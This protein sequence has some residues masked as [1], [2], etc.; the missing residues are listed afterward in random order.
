LSQKDNYFKILAIGLLFSLFF[1][2]CMK[3]SDLI[4]NESESLSKTA[5]D[6]DIVSDISEYI[7]TFCAREINEEYHILFRYPQFN[8]MFSNV[9]NINNLILD[10]VKIAVGEDF[11][12]DLRDTSE[13]CEWDDTDYSLKAIN[14]NYE[15]TRF[16]SDYLSII[17]TGE[18]HH[19]PAAYPNDYFSTLVVDLNKHK[20]IAL[21]DLYTVNLSFTELLEEEIEKQILLSPRFIN[22]DKNQKETVREYLKS[23]YSSDDLLKKLRSNNAYIEYKLNFYLTYEKLGIVF[24]LIHSI[25]D[26]AVALINYDELVDFI[27]DYNEDMRE[28]ISHSTYEIDSTE[29]VNLNEEKEINIRIIFPQVI[30]MNDLHIQN[31]IN[32][33]I[34]EAALKP[35]KFYQ[36]YIFADGTEWSFDGTEWLIEYSIVF[37]TDT[38]LSIKFKGYAYSQGNASGVNWVYAVNIDIANGNVITSDE[39]F[40][41]SFKNNIRYNIFKSVDF[42]IADI[43]ESMMNEEFGNYLKDFEIGDDNFYFTADKFIIIVPISDYYQFSADYDELRNYV[44][45]DSPIWQYIY[46]FEGA[47]FGIVSED[48]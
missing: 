37:A 26:F 15:I 9:D 38:I 3:K 39:L 40:S 5:N 8:D 23:N 27:T 29:F 42:E 21:E 45:V 22:T 36:E 31:K 7:I 43:D 12:G 6:N 2:A 47:T 33:Q 34:E 24:P 17:F 28:I 19:K 48:D 35:Y 14:V 44:K 13:T 32:E 41:D 4:D 25:S 18:F 11:K 20:V 30:D 10:F 16:D 1:S 46:S